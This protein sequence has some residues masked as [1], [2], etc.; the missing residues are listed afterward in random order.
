[1]FFFSICHDAIR[2]IPVLQHDQVRAEDI[3]TDAEDHAADD[4][5]YACKSRPWIKQAPVVAPIRGA[6]EMTMSE[7]WKHAKPLSSADRRI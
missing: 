3:D 2:T 4:V 1:M 6:T 7:A 5:R